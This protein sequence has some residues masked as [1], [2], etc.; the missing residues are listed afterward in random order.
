[1]WDFGLVILAICMPHDS[2]PPTS[3]LQHIQDPDSRLESV[4][5]HDLVDGTG[6]LYTL[7][8]W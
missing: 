1:V 4:M 7:S 5:K 2:P 6:T 3:Q 8:T